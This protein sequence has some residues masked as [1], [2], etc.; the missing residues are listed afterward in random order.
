MPGNYN[1]GDTYTIEE[2]V[3][4]ASYMT[5]SLTDAGIPFAVNADQHFYDREQRKWLEDMQP[6]F[7]AIYG[8]Q[9]LPSQDLPE[10]TG[11]PSRSHMFTV[12]NCF[13]YFSNGLFPSVAHA[14]ATNDKIVSKSIAKNPKENFL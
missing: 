2:Q 3:A 1:E 5:Q 6:V 10:D 8:Q 12:A 4:F 11:Y 14:S 13:R 9:I 7:A